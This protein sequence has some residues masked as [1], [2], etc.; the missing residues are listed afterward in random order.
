MIATATT[1]TGFKG[2]ISY[3]QKEHEKNLEK[4][5]L[6]EILEK[7][8]IYGDTKK[9]SSQMR[10]ISKG[11]S[12]VSRPVLHVA[13][14]FHKDEKLNK[15][16]TEKAIN[17]VLKEIG[18]NKENNQ[19]FLVKHNDA[20]H[21]HYHAVIN[22]VGFDA[23]TIDTSYIK[24]KLQVICDKIEQEQGLR[25]T[26]GRTILYDPKSEKGYRF[27]T[28]EEKKAA[29]LKKRSYHIRD[30]S[31]K[32]SEEKNHI[33][34]KITE[35]LKDK[36]IN[37]ADKL[38]ST[39]EKESIQ[40]KFMENKNGISGISFRYQNQ[41]YKG[42]DLGYKW[43]QVSNNLEQNR[44]SLESLKN[45]QQS[46]YSTNKEDWKGIDKTQPS[47]FPIDYSK[48][49][50]EQQ[51][52]IMFTKDYNKAIESVVNQHKEEYKKKKLNP[53]TDR[54]FK[55]NGFKKEREIYVFEREGHRLEVQKKAFDI[56][57]KQ[58]Q[59]KYKRFEKESE[60]YNTLMNTQPK[61]E[62]LLF[63]KEKI[64]E[65]NLKLHREKKEAIKPEFK[66]DNS[67]LDARTYQ[68]NSKSIKDKL[69]ETNQDKF[70]SAVEKGRD[71]K[72]TNPNNLTIE[73]EEKKN[74]S[75]GLGM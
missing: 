14:S 15:E 58:V 21:E 69:N 3:V 42:T 55:E 50:T 68:I 6:P 65:E 18:V 63:G 32:L 5:E 37:T 45:Q 70:K 57:T 75:K 36:N 17:S 2:V 34:T 20:K 9:M 41:A 27:L 19:Y 12:R 7:N 29:A 74:Q 10:F 16:Q 67:V 64:I 73:K 60:N 13:I 48:F 25:R 51:K 52:E 44:K 62:P 49:S 71:E 53:D 39:L 56:A 4:Y 54:I 11:N 66:I 26:N 40:T 30:K 61:K 23:K 43:K 33:K 22:K 31:S 24:N 38:K 59:E 35:A 47:S 28:R 8:N 72:G 46:I 1:G